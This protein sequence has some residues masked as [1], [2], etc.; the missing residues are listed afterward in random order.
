MTSFRWALVAAFVATWLVGA[1][2]YLWVE[3]QFYALPFS[4]EVISHGDEVSRAG[5]TR[6]VV[7]NGQG[8]VLTQT[9][10]DA[11]DDFQLQ[12]EA[13]D[14]AVAV[15]VFD[16]KRRPLTPPAPATYVTS[17]GLT[18]FVV[19][20]RGGLAVLKSYIDEERNGV[21]RETK[22]DGR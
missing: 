7:R 22:L 5:G 2:V 6:L 18:R 16:A 4:V 13:S 12:A 14:N 19:A 10:R 3:P 8:P 20:D 1:G 9:C 21:V 17:G 15:T 11:C